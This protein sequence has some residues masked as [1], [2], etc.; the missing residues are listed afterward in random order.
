VYLAVNRTSDA[1]A[2]FGAAA[3]VAAG[4]AGLGAGFA[5]AGAGAGFLVAGAGAFGAWANEVAEHAAIAMTMASARTRLGS[6]V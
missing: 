1:G 4:A 6:V 5:V 3:A 2:G